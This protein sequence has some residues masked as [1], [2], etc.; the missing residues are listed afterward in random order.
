V[1]EGA[2]TNSTFS[3]SPMTRVRQ[4]RQLKMRETVGL[5]ALRNADDFEVALHPVSP[6]V[7]RVRV[8]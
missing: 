4:Y 8:K 7:V 6:M 2:A 3:T 1:R 5:S